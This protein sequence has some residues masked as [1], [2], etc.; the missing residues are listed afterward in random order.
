MSLIHDTL[1]EVSNTNLAAHTPEVGG[2]YVNRAYGGNNNPITVIGGAGYATVASGDALY[3]NN[4]VVPADTKT[5]L[6]MERAGFSGLHPSAVLRFTDLSNYYLIGHNE[7]GP[8][9]RVTR[10]KGGVSST[11]ATGGGGI[12]DGQYTMVVEHVGANIKV[13]INGNTTPT[14]DYTDPDPVV[15]G[16]SGVF[17]GGRLLTYTVD[18]MAAPSFTTQPTSQTVTVP[19]AATF[20][21]ATSGDESVVWQENL[22]GTWT[23]LAN[24]TKTL[25]IN[26]TVS[27]DN[28]R[29]FRL[30]ATNSVGS[31]NSDVVTL[32]I[33]AG[34]PVITGPSGAAGAAN[35]TAS[36]AENA[37]TGPTFSTSVALGGGYPTL[38]GVD[39]ALW[40]ITPLTA[41]SWRVDPNPAKNFEN[42]TDSGANNVHNVVFNASAS[43]SQAC[44]ITITNVNEA[45]T[46]AG[47]DLAL[48]TLSLSVLMTPVDAAG[49][50][51]DPDSG[52]AGTYSAIGT[53]PAGV[54]VSLA[55]LISGTPTAS[56]TYSNLRVRRTDGGGLTADSN[57]FTITVAAAPP[58]TITGQ[59]LKNNT[60][61]VLASFTIPKVA[62]VRLSDMAPVLSLTNQTTNGSGIPAFTSALMEAGATYVALLANADG[63]S[64]GAFT[65]VA[66]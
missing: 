60:G 22:S 2:A 43:V 32:S 15:S 24:T 33:S 49:R 64:L 10:V 41:T 31:T 27:G 37:T 28:G 52:D 46:F 61:T 30:R 3:T 25:T 38:T 63:T 35:S 59:P 17:V 9:W 55:G 29:Q 58:V 5:T 66:A 36:V 23:D 54:T 53:W 34:P 44:A 8:Y 65:A 40:V 4:K 20:T 50:F 51:A 18:A 42:P 56:G 7:Y 14:I 62:V 47:P 13:F 6:V 12:S 57:L 48:S 11:A 21:A 26:P 45:P 39:A 16:L 1:T 19:A